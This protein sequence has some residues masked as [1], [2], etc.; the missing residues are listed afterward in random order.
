[1]RNSLSILL[2]IACAAGA[3]A[4]GCLGTT[5][6]A[7][8]HQQPPPPPPQ[9]PPILDPVVRS[10]GCSDCRIHL[11]GTKKFVGT[12]KELNTAVFSA[13]LLTITGPSTS[14][15]QSTWYVNLHT[16]SAWKPEASVTATVDLSNI[17]ADWTKVKM[18]LQLTSVPPL[19]L[20]SDIVTM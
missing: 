13:A 14:G 20:D 3:V 17:D 11:V 15:V 6:A 7:T 18:T 5:E 8:S 4:L 1:M 16:T 19:D 2:L 9:D 12:F 10:G